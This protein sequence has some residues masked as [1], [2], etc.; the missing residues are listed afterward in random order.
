MLA[1]SLLSDLVRP[2]TQIC[3]VND[4]TPDQRQQRIDL[5]KLPR[6]VAIVL[7]TN[8]ACGLHAEWH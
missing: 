8:A 4:M 5:E 2:L 1:L 3:L 6:L 7:H